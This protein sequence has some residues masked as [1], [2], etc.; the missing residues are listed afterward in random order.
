MYDLSHSEMYFG[1]DIL[2]EENPLNMMLKSD[3][4]LQLNL[5]K[6]YLMN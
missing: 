6:V 5:N 3:G 1:F 4:R 2:E